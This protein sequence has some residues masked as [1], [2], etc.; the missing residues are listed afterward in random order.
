[1]TRGQGLARAKNAEAMADA[2]QRLGYN[3]TMYYQMD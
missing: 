2:L 1:M 3:A